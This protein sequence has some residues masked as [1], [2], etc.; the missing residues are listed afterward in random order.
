MCRIA[1]YFGN[2]ITDLHTG[3]ITQM[4]DR[5]KHGGPDHQEVKTFSQAV[6]GHAR[7]SILDLSEAANQPF[8]W[9]D[10]IICFNGEIYNFREI[11]EK[12]VSIGYVFQTSS[13]TEVFIKAYDAWGLECVTLFVGMFAFAIWDRKKVQ[14]LIGRDRLGVKPLY[15]IRKDNG[16][17]FFSELKAAHSIR[18]FVTDINIGALGQYL[19]KGYISGNKCIFHEI[20]KLEPGTIIIFDSSLNATTKKYWNS[21]ES[22][23]EIFAGNYNDA[24]QEVRKALVKSIDYRF[25]S[26]VPVGVFLSG[27]ID[28]SIVTALAAAESDVK[29]KTFTIAFENKQYNESHLAKLIAERFST[30]HYEFQCSENIL[31]ELINELPFVYDE[32]FADASALPTLFLAQQAHKHVKVALGGDGGDEIFGGYVKYAVTRSFQQNPY[33]YKFLAS[34]V[35]FLG[36]ENVVSF[37]RYILKGRYRNIDT[38]IRKFL[39]AVNSE[40]WVDFFESASDF[41]SSDQL[42]K[43]LDQVGTN[44]SHGNNKAVAIDFDHD[45]FVRVLGLLDIGHYLPDDLLTKVD[46]A[47]MRYGLEAREPLLDH[48]LMAL[49]LSLPDNWKIKD[50]KGKWILRD[51]LSDYLPAQITNAPK[52]GFS[53]PVADWLMNQLYGEV[54]A[55]RMD[56]VFFEKFRLSETYVNHIL[57]TFYNR[58]P[59][60]DPQVIWN[61]LMLYKWYKK[62]I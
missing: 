25:V 46:R 56:H 14:F 53:V 36:E 57:K 47:T 62:W 40:A 34:I 44:V 7:L 12:L 54:E 26:D 58:K 13:D 45:Q 35:P 59:I 9:A 3:T 52:S 60:T 21:S 30:D 28:S 6:F 8:E 37:G 51:I 17:Y 4:I 32:P 20:E 5:M 43:L 61:L 50:G 38:K 55:M 19:R 10:Y 29:L 39:N 33:K 22:G 16:V 2:T 18:S 1:G 11:R 48:N 49:G 24:K 42:S 41:L 15:Y 31:L 23:K 27:G